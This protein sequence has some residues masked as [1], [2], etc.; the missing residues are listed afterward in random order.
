MTE[1]VIS[2]F[3]GTLV[4]RKPEIFKGVEPALAARIRRFQAKGNRFVIAT[5]RHP[6]FIKKII[7]DQFV[8]DAIIGFSGNIVW[9]HGEVISESF[10]KQEMEEFLSVIDQYHD[11]LDMYICTKDN[12]FYFYELSG[13]EYNKR[14]G[15]F[16]L[17]EPKDIN[18]ISPL[19]IKEQ[20]A[21]QGNQ[22]IIARICIISKIES[23]ANHCIALLREIFKTKYNYVLTN[24]NQIEVSR[25]GINKASRAEKIVADFNHNPKN[26]IVVGDS[27]NDISMFEKF[28]ESYCM[29]SAL[30]NVKNKAKYIISNMNELFESIDSY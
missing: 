11:V 23:E 6:S 13:V 8:P 3:D 12:D 1:I 5:G 17:D 28:E 24:P 4:G 29:S 14:Y 18:S 15:W 19:T 9:A 25:R 7:K 2:D 10:S 21:L 20:Y 27:Y 16:A 22:E 30:P 26:T